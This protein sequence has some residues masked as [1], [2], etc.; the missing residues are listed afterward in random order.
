MSEAVKA[1]DA[2]R[3][4][5]EDELR[6]VKAQLSAHEA[7]EKA[8][9]AAKMSELEQ[10]LQKARDEARAMKQERD[11]LRGK[12]TSLK[13]SSGVAQEGTKAANGKEEHKSS[14]G[15]DDGSESKGKEA[16][17]R[18]QGDD[19]GG[20]DGE[21]KDAKTGTR[22]NEQGPPDEKAAASVG[23]QKQHA[24]LDPADEAA[25]REFYGGAL[26][27]EEFL[28]K[29]R[30]TQALELEKPENYML[31]LRVRHPR[32]YPT[33]VAELAAKKAASLAE[34]D[35]WPPAPK[36]KPW[37][38]KSEEAGSSSAAVEP[39]AANAKPKYR[40]P[41]VFSLPVGSLMFTW[42]REQA[43]V[44]ERLPQSATEGYDE[45]KKEGAVFW[46]RLTSREKGCTIDID[47]M[48]ADA[49]T[50]SFGSSSASSG[51]FTHFIVTKTVD[52]DGYERARVLLIA[53]KNTSVSEFD[54]FF[55]ASAFKSDNGW[56]A[57]VTLNSS[58]HSKCPYSSFQW[59]V[60]GHCGVKNCDHANCAREPERRKAKC[61]RQFYSREKKGQAALEDIMLS[62]AAISRARQEAA[63]TVEVEDEPGSSSSL[64]SSSP[65][66]SS[67][68]SA[69]ASSSSSSKEVATTGTA[70]AT[71]K[72]LA[73]KKRPRTDDGVDEAE[74]EEHEAAAALPRPAKK[75]RKGKREAAGDAEGDGEDG[76]PPFA[77]I[78]KEAEKKRQADGGNGEAAK[79]PPAPASK[80]SRFL[81]IEVA[82]LTLEETEA[83]VNGAKQL[84][85]TLLDGEEVFV[86]SLAGTHVKPERE[87]RFARFFVHLSKKTDLADLRAKGFSGSPFEEGWP[88]AKTTLRLTHNYVDSLK[89]ATSTSCRGADE[90]SCK[91]PQCSARGSSQESRIKNSSLVGATIS[92]P[93]LNSST[94]DSLAKFEKYIGNRQ[95]MV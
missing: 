57:D 70:N 7:L 89:W 49:E 72:L 69:S 58:S 48:K 74:G 22:G 8:A 66:E 2:F 80:A 39:D 78:E 21:D 67:S 86:V 79:A 50:F 68:S 51:F 55:R 34:G 71:S 47:A 46:T 75:A 94:A 85:T 44:T 43:G 10:Q 9:T 56:R 93:W 36:I 32:F 12:L 87:T 15:D 52:K 35:T 81:E 16:D 62:A 38:S 77:S 95:P 14:D 26:T 83:L 64:S 54:R 19:D 17:E 45:S 92:G 5:K 53:N 65:S 20:D 3:S 37:A 27:Y 18:S 24:A 13:G 41:S 31:Q 59:V 30:E 73:G 76:K 25:A 42:K 4:A 84:K 6:S 1:A 90:D 63:L 88:I 61:E 33:K 11:E 23:Q 91:H 40:P 60:S 29:P 28:T 82:G